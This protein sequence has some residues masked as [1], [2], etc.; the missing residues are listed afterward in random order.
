MRTPTLCCSLRPARGLGQRWQSEQERL[1]HP[2]VEE[3]A[4]L[5][6]QQVTGRA[7]PWRS[8]FMFLSPLWAGLSG[9][10]FASRFK[11]L[12]PR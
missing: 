1:P 5:R 10:K 8:C 6:A 9:E 11:G 2:L 3:L 4:M 7:T 12:W